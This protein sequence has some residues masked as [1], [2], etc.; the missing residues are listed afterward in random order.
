MAGT[1]A[2]VRALARAS[3]REQHRLDGADDEGQRHATG[4]GRVECPMGQPCFRAGP[5]ID[6]QVFRV[7]PRLAMTGGMARFEPE[8]FVLTL[9]PTRVAELL[10]ELATT[11][12]EAPVDEDSPTVRLISS[13]DPSG[14]AIV[15]ACEGW[16]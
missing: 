13:P 4:H 12:P 8:G 2:I 6:R 7:G 3:V 9:D 14:C 16:A 11:E 10:R 5:C 15:G 1:W